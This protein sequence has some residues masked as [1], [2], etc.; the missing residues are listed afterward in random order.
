MDAIKL[1]ERQHEEVRTLFE[2]LE[3]QG[4]AAD[5][6]TFDELARNLVAHDAIERELF[7]PACEKA[8]GMT[9]HL[10]ESLVEH[11]YVEFGLYQADLAVGEDSF[12]AKLGVLKEMVLH[13]VSEE[14]EDF[15][16]E[17]RAAIDASRLNELG[18][19]MSTRF[20]EVKR[21]DV[22]ELTRQNLLQVM[23][24]ALKTQP[25]KSTATK[26]ASNGRANERNATR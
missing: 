8:M 1:L 24:G 2:K 22:R 26:S 5:P 21:S 17:V 15:F 11:G 6:A 18:N 20:E 19:Q 16:P 23:S 12:E 7:Y 10:A 13:H 25:G 3:S 4:E 9:H 14:E